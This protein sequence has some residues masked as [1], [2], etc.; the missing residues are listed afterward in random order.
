MMLTSSATNTVGELL[1]RLNGSIS[2]T[3]SAIYHA[4]EASGD[5]FEVA[6]NYKVADSFRDMDRVYVTATATKGAAGKAVN[7]AK[8]QTPSVK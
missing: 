7:S 1:K 2:G 3:C 5:K 8:E 6:H 4:P